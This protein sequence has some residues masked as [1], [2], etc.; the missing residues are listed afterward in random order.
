MKKHVTQ[1]ET[2]EYAK[3]VIIFTNYP[4]DSFS[5]VEIL[6]W[7]RGRWQVELTFKR[8]KSIAQLGHLPKY[9]D[10]SSE[11]W[12]YGKLFVKLFIQVHYVLSIVVYIEPVTALD[13]ALFR[14]VIIIDFTIHE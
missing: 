13:Q 1:P 5:D 10:D 9:R 7:Y 14:G 12:L 11:A 4:E 3:Y 8:F 2:M 6:E